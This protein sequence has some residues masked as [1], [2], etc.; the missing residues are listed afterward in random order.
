MHAA[1]V[2]TDGRF[3]LGVGSGQ[4]LNEHILGDPWPAVDERMDML[5]ESIEVIRELWS[6]RN[7]NH[8]GEHYKVVNAKLYTVTEET[9]PVYVSEQATQL[10]TEDMVA[11]SV[12]CGPDLGR[13]V[14]EMRRHLDAGFDDV[15]VSQMGSDADA[16]FQA[17][18]EHVLPKVR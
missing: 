15:Y 4:A 7:I 9:P 1:W 10:V 12:V 14:G 11:D 16:F 5:E 13:H 6:G 18:S 2:Q 3:V 8:D 17:Y